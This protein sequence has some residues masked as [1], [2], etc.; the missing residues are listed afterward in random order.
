MALGGQF[1]A[2]APSSQVA[3]SKTIVLQGMRA[4]KWVIQPPP[5]KKGLFFAQKRPENGN[6][7]PKKSVY[8]GLGGKFKV[9]HP[10]LQVLNSNNMCSS[11][12]Q[13]ENG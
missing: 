4:E 13:A 5:P 8:L 10:I 9:P 6:S 12:W 1:K 7:A 2:S 11:I 3:D